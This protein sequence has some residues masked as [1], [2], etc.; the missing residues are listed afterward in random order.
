[1]KKFIV[2]EG[3]DG[4]GKSTAAELL[5]KELSYEFLE[6]MVEPYN[7]R[8]IIADPSVSDD[9]KHFLSIASTL[10]LSNVI[11]AKIGEGKGVV[12]SRH[13]SSLVWYYRAF[14]M[15][16]KSVPI[17]TDPYALGCLRP[18]ISIMLNINEGERVKR[19]KARG[20]IDGGERIINE[21]ADFRNM[22]LAGFKQDVDLVVDVDNLSPMQV[23]EE[24]AKCIR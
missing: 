16:H 23:V 17:K 4:S 11:R 9:S 24:L 13:V 1:M 2:L 21:N 5:A 10:H 20:D 12:V 6:F 3:L 14:C 8:S 19:L 15:L 7:I 22:L 18:D